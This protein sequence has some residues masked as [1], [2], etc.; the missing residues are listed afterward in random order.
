MENNLRDCP[1]SHNNLNHGDDT[2][3]DAMLSRVETTDVFRM[4]CSPT[5][6]AVCNVL[7]DIS[8]RQMAMLVPNK[9]AATFHFEISHAVLSPI[10][11]SQLKLIP[12]R[13]ERSQ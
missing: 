11:S 7:S 4:G 1:A 13:R 2:A 9:E 12:G 3:P 8:G 5:C 10:H 6:P